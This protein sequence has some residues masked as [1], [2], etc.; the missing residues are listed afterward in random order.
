VIVL[1]VIA[2]VLAYKAAFQFPIY[3]SKS[4]STWQGGSQTRLFWL[5]IV[6]NIG[7]YCFLTCKTAAVYSGGLA[8]FAESNQLS[9]FTS[10]P[11]HCANVVCCWFS[12][13]D[14]HSSVPLWVYPARI[15]STHT[16]HQIILLPFTIVSCGD[17][18]IT[19]K[20][21][22]FLIMYGLSGLSYSSATIWTL[23]SGSTYMWPFIC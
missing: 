22:Y 19:Q 15:H 6:W 7:I 13:E 20:K 8:V 12:Q 5:G 4:I 21:Y 11:Q 23:L 3:S 2:I 16:V 9:P 10:L 14:L 1:I 18:N 17:C